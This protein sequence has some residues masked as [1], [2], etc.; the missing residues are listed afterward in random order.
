MKAYT[1]EELSYY[2]PRHDLAIEQ[3]GTRPFLTRCL[4]REKRQ[5]LY[6]DPMK[7]SALCEL[8]LTICKEPSI[9]GASAVLFAVGKKTG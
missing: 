5:R 9:L 8:E 1:P 2:F 7:T 3:I 6:R 4:S